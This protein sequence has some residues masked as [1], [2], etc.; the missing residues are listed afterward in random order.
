MKDFLAGLDTEELKE[1]M[2]K[3]DFSVVET[4]VKA[5]NLPET[6][7]V[8][9]NRTYTRLQ[10]SII[11]INPKLPRTPAIT[12]FVPNTESRTR[13][14]LILNDETVDLDLGSKVVNLLGNTNPN[15]TDEEKEEALKTLE[16]FQKR[17]TLAIDMLKSD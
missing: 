17:V 9:N 1:M 4:T 7:T 6:A 13:A 2:N 15:L 16:D 5:E 12:R 3:E 11:R 14:T 10:N 8:K